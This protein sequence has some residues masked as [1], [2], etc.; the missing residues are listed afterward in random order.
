[1][2]EIFVFIDAGLRGGEIFDG[3]SC[4]VIMYCIAQMELMLVSERGGNP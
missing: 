1:M 4:E 2:L 3:A